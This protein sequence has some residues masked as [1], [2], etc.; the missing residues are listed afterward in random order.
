MFD[1]W[2]VGA[3]SNFKLESWSFWNKCGFTLQCFWAT[4]FYL[5]L[6]LKCLLLNPFTSYH[7]Q[8]IIRPKYYACIIR[9]LRWFE[10]CRDLLNFILCKVKFS[11][12]VIL[13]K[14]IHDYII[15]SLFYRRFPWP[16]SVW[17]FRG[18]LICLTT[19]FVP[20]F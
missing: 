18:V 12:F 15:I 11:D 2:L 13:L 5:L 7:K 10:I 19:F 3:T 1:S 6:N 14:W 16:Q 4:I 9:K 20:H 17:I 8:V